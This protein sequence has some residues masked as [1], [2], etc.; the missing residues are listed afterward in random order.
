MPKIIDPR[1]VEAKKQRNEMIRKKFRAFMNDGR[2]VEWAL[3][4]LV[5][6][7][8]LSESTITQIVKEYGNYKN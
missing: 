4:E 1:V 5:K 7:W 6:E 3:N 2:T 8:G